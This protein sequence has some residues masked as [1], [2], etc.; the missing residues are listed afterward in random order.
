M[1]I[2]ISMALKKDVIRKFNPEGSP[3]V[4][5]ESQQLVYDPLSEIGLRL[6]QRSM[7]R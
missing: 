5:P 4:L 7:E 2:A 3:D 1:M 6:E